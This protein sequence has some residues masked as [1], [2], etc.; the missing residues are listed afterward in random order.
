MSVL[1]VLK[2]VEA[3]PSSV[4]LRESIWAYPIVETAHVLGLCLFLGL[5]L[6]L[7]LRLLDLTLRR[8]TVSEMMS[9]LMPWMAAGFVVMVVTGLLL[10][11]SD[12][13]R[14]FGNIFFQAKIVML[15]LAGL[16]AYLFERS[17]AN[18][19]RLAWEGK[20][21]TPARAKVAASISLLLWA[22]IVVAGRMIAYNWFD[23]NNWFE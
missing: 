23:P 4:A 8:V 11:Y 18:K 5:T 19:N 20:P 15:V 9:R 2:W 1:G 14:F 21:G 12:P 3:L 7:D 10:L 13:I 22:S 6:I 16:N 17:F